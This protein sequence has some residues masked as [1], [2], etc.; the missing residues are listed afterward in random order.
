MINENNYIIVKQVLSPE[1]CALLAD[2]ARLKARVKPN[3]YKRSDPLKNV[4]REY[5]DLM[6]ET[7]LDKFT[8]IVEHATQCLLWPT[9]SFYYTY[10]PGNTL[11]PHT[12]RS[13]CQYVAGLCIGADDA[14]KKKH[15]TW[16]LLFKLA[17]QTESV[18]VDYGDLVIFKGHE[19]EHWRE[20]FTGEWFIS[21]IF[22]YVDQAGP[23]AFQKYD[24]RKALGKPHVGMFRW[25]FGCVKHY[26]LS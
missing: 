2:Y 20:A 25:L 14:F 13:S 26:M 6:M 7:L 4:H 12:D 16:P 8:P 21:A 15:G 19:I 1:M 9:L 3:R 18:A 5:G 23:Y 11:A 10:E 24:Q 17:G 22:G